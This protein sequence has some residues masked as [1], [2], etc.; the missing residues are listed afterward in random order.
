VVVV[1]VVGGGCGAGGVGDSG[2]GGL[3]CITI[4]NFHG[5]RC[6]HKAK[7]YRI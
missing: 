5:L 2:N 1:V 4:F 3:K 7:M 6:N